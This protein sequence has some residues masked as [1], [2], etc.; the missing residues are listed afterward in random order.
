MF[1]LLSFFDSSVIISHCQIFVNNFFIFL[2]ESFFKTLANGEGGIRTHAPVKAN[3]FQD[4]LVMTTSI[5]LQGFYSFF[6]TGFSSATSDILSLIF[7]S[8]NNIFYFFLSFFELF[9][10]P[11]YIVVLKGFI[12]ILL[13]P[14]PF[15]FS[16]YYTCCIYQIIRSCYFYILIFSHYYF[17]ISYTRILHHHTII[18]YS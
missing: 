13:W 2:Q 5:P 9:F 14:N 8:V 15:L 4:R 17:Y 16:I 10:L 7:F 11:Q 3:G 18:C 6:A 12:H 1:S